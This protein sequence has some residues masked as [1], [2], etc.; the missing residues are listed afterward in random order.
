MSIILA[1]RGASAYA[2]E[3]TMEAFLLAQKMG[4]DGFELDVH[5]SSDGELIVIHDEK[6][7]RTTDGTGLICELSFSQIKKLNASYGKTGYRAAKVPVLKEALELIQGTSLILNIEIKTDSILYPGIEEKTVHTV[8]KLGLSE[9]IIYS[10]FNH[11]SIMK[12]KQID[13]NA[14]VGLLYT[15]PLYEPWKYAETLHADYLHPYWPNVKIPAYAS[16]SLQHNVGVN[17]WTVNSAEAISLCA[18]EGIGIIT[19]YPDK[20]ININKEINNK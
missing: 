15:T 7:D 6:A 4:A 8:R 11:Y 5:L 1:H 2:P 3:N 20:A 17:A 13:P 12:I 10:S 14:K 18:R 16:A 9:Q 19:N